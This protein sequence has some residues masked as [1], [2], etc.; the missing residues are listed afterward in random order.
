MDLA[1]RDEGHALLLAL[2]AG[3]EDAF[4]ALVAL[5]GSA[6]LRFA[7]QHVSSRA[8][9]EEVVQD[10]WLAVYRGIGRFEGRSSLRTWLFRI[11]LYRSVSRGQR[12][13]RI[14]PSFAL[15]AG[16]GGAE[17]ETL[18]SRMR[19]VP[20][21][22][23]SAGSPEERLLAL[24]ARARIEAAI[25]RLPPRQQGVLVLRDVE[26]WDPKEVC[27][28][29]GLSAGNQRVLLHRARASVRSRLAGYFAGA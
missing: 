7:Q 25:A 27:E 23:D 12:E 8:V 24:E 2:R 18:E 5:H 21:P 1:E 17:L 6:M 19:G 20:L 16:G 14:V 9:A 26:G 28:V 4:A 22:D 3:D 10:T 29:L 15:S 13:R 11:L